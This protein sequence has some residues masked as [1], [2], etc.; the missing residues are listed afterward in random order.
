MEEEDK[1]IVYQKKMFTLWMA[2]SRTIRWL[3]NV[4]QN[5][6]LI[7]FN[8]AKSETFQFL[9]IVEYSVILSL[10]IRYF[11]NIPFWYVTYW[12]SVLICNRW[13]RSSSVFL[14]KL[15][16]Q[17]KF[18]SIIYHIISIFILF[19]QFYKPFDCWSNFM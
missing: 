15:F 8:N 18:I 2:H 1:C 7:S 13:E 11:H 9:T 17:F 4:V 12:P 6:F 16:M 3:V 10:V 19:Q 14:I 5:I